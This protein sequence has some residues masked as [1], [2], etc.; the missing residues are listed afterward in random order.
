[1]P[2]ADLSRS[3][4]RNRARAFSL[5]FASASSEQGERQTFWNEFFAIFG[6]DRVQVAVF[7]RLAQRTTTGRHGWMDLLYPG[8]MA[9]EHKSAGE[10]LGKAMKQL[11][12]YLPNLRK[13]EHP[14]L[15]VTCDF[16]RFAWEDLRSRKKGQFALPDL[17]D[18]LE[19]FWWL[20]GHPDPNQKFDSEEDANLAAT[21]KMRVLHVELRGN[22]FPEHALREWLTRIL[23]CLF[24]DDTGVWD[25]RGAFHTWVA[26]MTREDGSDLGSQLAYLFQILN[27]P[28]AD[29]PRKLDEQVAQF[30]YINGDL[31]FEALPVA[32]CT[33]AARD[34][35]LEA[36]RFNWTAISPAIFGSM[37]QN[38]M[39]ATERRQLGA[40]Y[41]TEG[42]ILKTIGPLF[43]D[44]LKE[45]L[46]KADS[47]PKLRA[48]LNGLT[49]L[50]FLDPACGC[51]NFLV[52]AYRE[53]RGLETEALRRL[54]TREG[55]AAQQLIDITIECRVRVDQFY[56]IEIEEFPAKIA[57]TALYLMDHLCNREV[58]REFGQHY[59]RFP[60]PA[61]PH[62]AV[63]NALRTNWSELLPA[64]KASYIFGNPPFLGQANRTPQQTEDLRFVWGE[65]YARWLDY[66]SGWHWKA[67]AYMKAGKNK[68]RSAFVSTN[69]ITQGEQVARIWGP[70]LSMGVEI[71]AAHR[72]FKW[73]NEASGRAAVHVVIIV[74]S[75][76]PSDRPKRLWEYEKADGDPV[77]RRVA[78]I[79]PYLL[80]RGNLLVRA[81]R[82]PIGHHIPHV[83]YGNKPA[84][85]GFLVLT[86]KDLPNGDPIAMKY[87]REYIGTDELLDGKKRWCL[88]IEEGDLT[89]ASRSS[90]IK[91][92]VASVRKFRLASSAADTR[93]YADRPYR[94]FRVPQPTT[95]YLAVPSLVSENRLWFTVGHLE[96]SVIASNQLFTANDP[97]GIL[98]G[99]LSSRMFIVWLRNIGGALESRLRFSQLVYTSFP[100]PKTETRKIEAIQKAGD[101]LLQARANHAS[102]PLSVLYQPDFMPDDVSKAH[103][104]LDV[105]VESAFAPRRRFTTDLERLETL[106]D[107]Y[108]EMS[109][110]GG[111]VDASD[112]EGEP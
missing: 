3:E 45:A 72:T 18:N 21:E 36:C 2:T 43:L 82:E 81:W 29:R 69:S 58:S 59:A 78:Q 65:H 22:G 7:E 100:F 96:P 112:V 24:A 79:N 26:S 41:T 56:G 34:A 98:F 38:V 33:A 94:F 28:I 62:I 103:K 50:T 1:M 16:K 25:N 85:G 92:R 30:T 40:H 80:P 102:T 47:K 61:S 51:G 107:L 57:R 87:V 111:P 17:A 68:P 90:F 8:Q 37:F 84:D 15:L 6:L 42:N 63:A 73:R 89:E 10:D 77:E 32:T 46:E 109:P 53:L 106:F 4:L 71:E 54:R 19:L 95:K 9:V 75:I 49:K 108:A 44:D 60:I 23:F 20:A 110:E 55:K 101:G 99:L 91:T 83:S 5:R 27:T 93:K 70:M 105:A 97:D 14:W 52:I 67:A 86:Q 39:S 13:A 74:F 48:F 104:K 31:F 88:W 64:D 12:D 66:V 76:G 35:L 11:Y